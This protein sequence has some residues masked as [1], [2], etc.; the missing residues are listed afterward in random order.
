MVGDLK[1]SPHFSSVSAIDLLV[2]YSGEFGVRLIQYPPVDNF[3]NSHHL[4]TW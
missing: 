4:F 3:L 1:K 2:C